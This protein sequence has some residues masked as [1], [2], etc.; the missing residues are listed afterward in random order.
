MEQALPTFQSARAT[1]EVRTV[2]PLYAASLV[3]T[4]AAVGA[5][6]VTISATNW[7]SI[8]ALL[9]ILGHGVSYWLRQ[10][11]VPS[12]AVFYPVMLL[13]STV[14]FQQ[15]VV[16]SPLTGLD[17]PI[18]GLP[19][20]QA[21]AIILGV[22][23]VIRSFTLLTNGSLIFSPVPAIAMM[24]LAGSANL[25]REIPVYFGLV[26][27]GSVFLTSFDAQ[28]RR[29]KDGRTSPLLHHLLTA[30]LLASVV[31]VAAMI[32]ALILQPI[33]A[34]LSP[35]TLPAMSR[36]RQ[37]APFNQFNGNQ[38]PVGQG[39]IRLSPIPVYRI[40]TPEA[41]LYR[42]G[43]LA[44]YTGKGWEQQGPNVFENALDPYLPSGT[45]ERQV[46]TESG[47]EITRNMWEFRF[48]PYVDLKNSLKRRTVQQR[49][50]VLE[51]PPQG[52]P[53]IG[54]VA[55][56]IYP[57]SSV[58]YHVSEAVSGKSHQS[59]GAVIELTS[60]LVDFPPDALRKAPTVD[61][62]SFVEPDTLELPQSTLRVQ[63]LARKITADA[64]TAY[65][66]LQAIIR[67]IEKNCAY[68][69]MEE[70]TPAGQDA[71]DFYL[72]TSKR[73]A[74]G[75]AATA[76]VVMAR[77]V[78]IPARVAIGYVAE[79][80]LPQG[81][82]YL[83]RQ[84]HAHMWVEGFFPGY[85]WVEFNPAPSLTET[86]ENPAMAAWYRLR[87]FFTALT[88][89]GL[90]AMLL[91]AVVLATLALVGY[92]G[93][94]A[95]SGWRARVRRE[96]EL[97]AAS[98]GLA[99]AL[100]YQRALRQLERRGWRREPWLTP[101][102]FRDAMREKWTAFPAALAA[103]EELTAIYERARYA[104]DGTPED[105]CEAESAVANLL[106]A[107]PSVPRDQRPKRPRTPAPTLVVRG[108]S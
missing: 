58:K 73:G 10:M 40:Q 49:I 24:A 61:A 38:A 95:F 57:G 83:I 81:D 3:I 1:S 88:G 17:A 43:S 98:P 67:Y 54:R 16:G 69:L 56:M 103:L 99:V 7:I 6:G 92:S 28:F 106:K 86:R 20:D 93:W 52:I 64:P 39:P 74:C 32:A 35:F 94:A 46:A 33:L 70:A 55:S 22:L 13:G 71:A 18:G 62:A 63:E 96:R 84:Q 104:G 72:F 101:S 37:A 11:R 76:T 14:A 100:I 60:Q 12:E 82:G 108:A 102:E 30:W 8:W 34:P 9:A 91:I 65:D 53:H 47:V 89:G 44:Y 97:F 107:A 59:N 21:T 51:F 105:L 68:T 27:L 85:G 41:G 48:Q 79:E 29:A 36:L 26:L 19:P 78:G 90:D 50:Q 75:L 31:C 23:A 87:N 77:A 5:V 80:P 45:T 25:N 42:T 4:L 15:L 2:L 66:K